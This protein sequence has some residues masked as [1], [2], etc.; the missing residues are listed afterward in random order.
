MGPAGVSDSAGGSCANAPP[1]GPK[2]GEGRGRPSEGPGRTAV[3]ARALSVPGFSPPGTPSSNASSSLASSFPAGAPQPLLLLPRVWPRRD[4]GQSA[5]GQQ[6]SSHAAGGGGRG[7][8]AGVCAPRGSGADSRCAP[9]LAAAC[10]GE[11]ALASS[12]APTGPRALWLRAAGAALLPTP[13]PLGPVLGPQGPHCLAC[14]GCGRFEPFGPR[15]FG[16]AARTRTPGLTEEGAC[17][18]YCMYKAHLHT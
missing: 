2:G 8:A 9:P 11:S 7:K 12:L 14:C 6:G 5:L 3:F 13:A 16:A 15:A 10:G 1:F 4:Q 18:A 17:V